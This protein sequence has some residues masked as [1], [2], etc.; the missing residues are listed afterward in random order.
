MSTRKSRDAFDHGSA[1]STAR[2]PHLQARGGVQGNQLDLSQLRNPAS[3]DPQSM[4][5]MQRAVGNAASVAQIT[6]V[7]ALQRDDAS[8]TSDAPPQSSDP[9]QTTSTP[10]QT[11]QISSSEG[12]QSL[13]TDAARAYLANKIEVS[14]NLIDLMAGE[15]ATLQKQRD[16]SI[17]MSVVGSVADVA[18]GFLTMPDPSLW[19][20]ARERI[21][22]ARGAIASGDLVAAGVALDSANDLFNTAQTTYLTYKNGNVDGA[23]NVISGLKVVIIADVAVGAALTG[24]ASLAATGAVAGEAAVGTAAATATTEAAGAAVAGAEATTAVAGAEA[25]TAA[26]TVGE[27]SLGTQAVANAAMGAEG[28][29]LKDA[30]EQADAGH[31]NW[32]EFLVKTGGGF[33]SGLLAACVSGPLKD[34]LQESC[35][36]RITE[37]LM[38]DAEIA[39]LGIGR[40][41]L[42]SE[43]RTWMVDTWA[44]KAGEWLIGKP[45]DA[46][47][48]AATASAATGDTPPT[49]AG[50]IESIAGWAYAPIADAFKAFRIQHG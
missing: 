17:L 48:D 40:D 29:A 10:A 19:A 36:S 4:I 38:S 18:G 32:S 22:D 11:A 23:K 2:E 15:N 37:E 20:P 21:D 13:P 26:G 44:D 49:Q 45:I 24:G 43:L 5:A 41:A 1:Q 34:M 25:A 39:A 30:G 8:G 50:A 7:R 35:A 9:A 14:A 6:G 27:A 12:E 47:T 46:V 33:A 28:A 42:Q 16:D 3:A 31:W